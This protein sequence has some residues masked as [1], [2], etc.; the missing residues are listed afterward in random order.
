MDYQVFLLSR[1]HERYG[2]VADARGAVVF[3]VGSTARII[4]GA[5][6]SSW[7]CSAASPPASW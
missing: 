6:S 3:G 4:T 2:Q 7:P 5:A 1:I